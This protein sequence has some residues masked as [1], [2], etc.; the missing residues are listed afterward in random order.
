MNS[1]TTLFGRLAITAAVAVLCW[2]SAGQ[3]PIG[4]RV[5]LPPLTGNYFSMQHTN[6]PPLPSL[7]FNVPVY[8]LG[9]LP[10]GSVG[11]AYDDRDIDYSA[12]ELE[13]ASSQ[14]LDS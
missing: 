2:P 1:R 11:Y 10:D 3:L 12:L 7:P 5:D 9:A 8:S 4:Q 14:M 13:S 6:W